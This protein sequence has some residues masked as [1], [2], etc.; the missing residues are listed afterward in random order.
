MSKP[1]ILPPATGHRTCRA[2][3]VHVPYEIHSRSRRSKRNLHRF[4]QLYYLEAVEAVEKQCSDE[5]P[6]FR[7]QVD[8]GM[9]FVS[10]NNPVV[11]E[12]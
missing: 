3:T 6:C 7:K 9:T 5:K 11:I 12:H 10:S 4:L 8:I 1:R 2:C